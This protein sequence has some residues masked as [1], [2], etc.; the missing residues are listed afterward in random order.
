MILNGPS[1]EQDSQAPGDFYVAQ[2]MLILI[3]W[4]K[5]CLPGFS[6][7]KLTISLQAVFYEKSLKHWVETSAINLYHSYFKKLISSL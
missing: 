3:T 4:L 6:T 7:V 2:V 5:W 1:S